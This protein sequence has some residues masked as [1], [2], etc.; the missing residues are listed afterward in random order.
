M[1]DSGI[2][3]YDAFKDN[4]TIEPIHTN[5]YNGGIILHLDA[6]L[7]DLNRCIFT[8]PTVDFILVVS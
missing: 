6:D 3:E 8:D 5:T 2:E 4:S 1:H 7:N